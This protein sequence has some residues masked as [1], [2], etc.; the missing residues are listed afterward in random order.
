[1]TPHLSAGLT[2]QGCA[3]LIVL[4]PLA[5][6][7]LTLTNTGFGRARSAAHAMLASMV[8]LA[9]AAIVYCV[10]GFSWEGFAGR[11]AHIFVLGGKPWNWVAREPFFLHGL[12]A[13]GSPADLAVLLQVFAV[14]F[15]ALIPISAGADRWRLR[16][17]CISTVLLAGFTYPVFAHWVWGGGWLSQLGSNY[18]LGHG[19]LDAGGASTIQVVGGLTSL[20]VTWILGPRRG[21][22]PADG[23]PAAIPGH[24]IVY[25]LLGCALMLPGWIGLNCTGAILFS[26]AVP[27]QIAFIAVNTML[28]AS[29]ALVAAV[30]VTRVRF[31]KPDASLCANGWVGGLV[32]SSAV[33]LFVTPIMAISVGLIAGVLVTVAVELLEVRLAIDDPGG[34]ISVHAVAGLWGLL[35]VGIVAQ[36]PA[37]ASRV[38]RS[39]GPGNSGQLLAQLVGIATLLGF[40]LPMTYGLNWLLDR[41]SPQRVEQEGER[42]GM[43]LHQLGAGA[44]PEFVI[45][46]NEFSQR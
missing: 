27:G 33:C 4:V 24:N 6:A 32:A 39:G 40:V 20:A 35:V 19:F 45:H 10:S 43:D 15:A 25:V 17:S 29:A 26:G 30:I 23:M 9:T 13:N 37:A 42:I 14:G 11:P 21:R 46:S 22:Y 34:A 7:G 28:S 1:M 18:G 44:Y 16:S 3:M 2:Q 12:G 38:L 36:I 8:T 5:L 41:I 31:G